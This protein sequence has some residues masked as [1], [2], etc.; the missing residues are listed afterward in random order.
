MAYFDIAVIG[1]DRRNLSMAVYFLE[2]G[3]RVICYGTQRFE[4]G[5]R[6][7]NYACAAS[8]A[9]TIENADIIVGGIPFEKNGIITSPEV[10]PD[11]YIEEM[12]NYMRTGKK[13]FGGLLTQEFCENCA[14]AGACC[15]DFMRDET[16]TIL[17]TVATAEGAILEALQNK[18]TNIHN[19]NSLV[20]GYGRCGRVLCEKLKGMSANVSV[21]SRKREE[22]AGAEVFGINTLDMKSLKRRIGEF[23][24]IYNTI[25]AITLT[26]NTLKNV[27]KDVLIIDIASAPGGVDYN[28][29]KSMGI[30]ALHCL[31]LPGKCAPRVSAEILGNYVIEKLMLSERGI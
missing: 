31:G 4:E 8:L 15:F 9:Q 24:Y 30:K 14:K 5:M 6:H 23:E 28:A 7:R 22:R 1:G 18:D 20:L 16:I 27:R 12:L 11:M 13:I 10:L 21:C 3:Y 29:A 19:S 2:K 25:P 17:N 26:G